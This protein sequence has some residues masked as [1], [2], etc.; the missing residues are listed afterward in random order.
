MGKEPDVSDA[1]AVSFWAVSS[2][3]YILYALSPNLAC[4]ELYISPPCSEM[5]CRPCITYVSIEHP[6]PVD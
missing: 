4:L 2:S 1:E 5:H 3:V 6:F